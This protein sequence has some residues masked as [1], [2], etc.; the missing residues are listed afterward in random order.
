M[1]FDLAPGNG[2]NYCKAEFA[3]HVD[4]ITAYSHTAGGRKFLYQRVPKYTLQLCRALKIINAKVLVHIRVWSANLLF[5]I[6]NGR[7]PY[8]S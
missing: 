8:A 5:V 3:L 7:N 6:V 2:A 1:T 4:L